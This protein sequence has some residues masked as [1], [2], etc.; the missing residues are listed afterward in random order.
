MK[1]HL[2]TRGSIWRK[3][4]LH[5]HAPSSALNNQFAGKTEDEKWDNYLKALEKLEDIS[6]LGITDYFSI[7]GYQKVIEYKNQ[8]KLQ[9]ID[10]IIPNVEMRMPIPSKSGQ[11]INFHILFDPEIVDELESRFFN[12]LTTYAGQEDRPYRCIDSDIIKLG[13]EQLADPQ[14]LNH[15]AYQKGIE[16]FKVNMDTIN[17]LF[18]NDPDLRRKSLIIVPNSDKDG[19]SVLKEDSMKSKR[20]ELYKNTDLIFSSNLKDQSYFIGKGTDDAETVKIKYG[21]LIPCIHGSDA[22][23]LE[24]IGNPELDRFTWIKADPTWNGLL[25]IIHEP[26]SRVVVQSNHPDNKTPYNVIDK[27]QFLDENDEFT[28]KPIYLN[29]ALNVIIGGK[30]SGKS[31]LLY[32]IAQAISSEEINKTKGNWT[33]IYKDTFI[34]KAEFEVTFENE[35]V[36]T[37]EE[38]N[39]RIQY[40][41]QMYINKMSEDRNNEVLQNKIK[42]ILEANISNT[43]GFLKVNER[44]EQIEQES[45]TKVDLLMG[46][47][48]LVLSTRKKVNELPSEKEVSKEIKEIELKIKNA[49]EAAKLTDDETKKYEEN[50][51]KVKEKEAELAEN[52][53]ATK[54]YILNLE[55]FT[56]I[57]T[58][59]IKD[60]KKINFKEE[61]AKGIFEN[62]IST[63]ETSKSSTLEKLKKT[64]K[65]YESEKEKIT[66]VIDQLNSDRSS[67]DEKLKQSNTIPEDQTKLKE[68]K[69]ILKEIKEVKLTLDETERD[70]QEI[71]NQLFNLKD[72]QIKSLI[73]IKE[74][75]NS[76]E[77]S[78]NLK[79]DAQINFSNNKFDENF[80]DLF[81]R[82]GKINNILKN[83]ETEIINDEDEFNYNQETY[84]DN[85]K[86]L[87]NIILDTSEEDLKLKRN[88]NKKNLF[89]ALL[90]QTYIDVQYDLIKDNDSLY[91]MS[92]GNRGL[93]LLELF[94]H[95]SE[96]LYPILID[97]PE[98]NLDNRTISRELVE[99]I[100][101]Q[102]SK[103][104]IIIVTH[105]ANL[106]VLTDAENIIVAN[107]DHILEY[108][109]E[110]RFEYITGS[111]ECSFEENEGEKFNDQ[112][113]KEHTSEI[114]EGGEEAFEVRRKKYGYNE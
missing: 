38:S 78:N 102:K 33:N 76:T 18:R 95:M 83:T 44:I 52:K 6:V 97:Q 103:R 100:R 43:E 109:S 90:K 10:L 71:E 73:R 107:Q 4:D 60:I 61:D 28:T 14:V 19:A 20:E 94:L 105:N 25:Q 66:K 108:N 16:Q 58:H 99:I 26:E 98:D 70:Q 3:W 85:M 37:K 72:E 62:F 40:I 110:T 53:E 51:K 17:E 112:G 32:K 57:F 113:I 91:Q 47:I 9:N 39:G 42:E 27:V 59:A 77:I 12:Q 34:D 93:V 65:Q 80:L 7:K 1:E 45:R 50:I 41:P 36:F 101:E 54:E 5:I 86:Y 69:A 87:Y 75:I 56:S 2:N 31:A 106:A 96:D 23:E 68:Q 15:V 49:I 74:L 35:E 29:P 21:K 92:P 111:L 67:I 88:S 48:D 63:V 79:A 81:Q 22:H 104:Q 11:V 46:Q 84:T 114:L 89:E 55:R 64:S 13:R 82:R 24:K 30:S 8:N